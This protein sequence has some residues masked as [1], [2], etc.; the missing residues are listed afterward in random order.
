[1]GDVRWGAHG[2]YDAQYGPLV[3]ADDLES[4]RQ[5]RF[6]TRGN[7]LC[8]VLYTGSPPAGPLICKVALTGPP[9][10]LVELCNVTKAAMASPT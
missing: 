6:A 9:K 3:S 10:W 2:P 7:S 8:S 5:V 1:M 4:R